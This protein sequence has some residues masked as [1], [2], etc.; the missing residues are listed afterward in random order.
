MPKSR[1]ATRTFWATITI[2]IIVIAIIGFYL[3]TGSMKPKPSTLQ[4]TIPE[5][6]KLQPSGWNGSILISNLYYDPSVLRVVIGI[7]NTVVWT[8]A[9]STQHTIYTVSVPT[10]VTS[11][12]NVSVQP[13]GS[14][15]YTFTTPGIYKYFC[16]IH[17]WM[18]G[19]V[20]VQS[21]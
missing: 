14:Y 7:N 2:I 12:G 5:G 1:A 15:S 6:A 10:G 13:G 4:I 16:N 8:N 19:E 21:G 9:D 18:G 17:P 11:F 3:Y 20:I